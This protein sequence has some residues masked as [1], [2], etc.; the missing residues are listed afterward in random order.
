MRVLSRFPFIL[1]LCMTLCAST[2]LAQSESDKFD[3]TGALS[4]SWDADPAM[5]RLN[6]SLHLSATDGSW[7][8]AVYNS[9]FA[10]NRVSMQWAAAPAAD[11]DGAVASGLLLVDGTSRNSNGYFVYY[12]SSGNYYLYRLEGGQLQTPWLD[13]SPSSPAPAP[14]G[15]LQIDYW[16]GNIN[17]YLD[18]NLKATLTDPQGERYT[19]QY[20]GI[21]LYPNR[22]NDIDGFK[23]EYSTDI[24]GGG[25]GEP[26]GGGGGTVVGNLI[27][28]TD[29]FCQTD[30]EKWAYDPNAMVANCELGIDAASDDGWDHVSVNKRAGAAGAKIVYSPDNSQQINGYIPAGFAILMDAASPDANGYLITKR[31][32]VVLYQ[33]SGGVVGDAIKN[34]AASQ[35][36]PTPGG[37]IKVII[38]QTSETSKFIQ[39]YVDDQL[40]VEFTFDNATPLENA[41]VGAV[42]YSTSSST[43]LANIT[44][45]TT[46]IEGGGDPEN[47][48]MV[49]GDGQSGLIEQWLPDTLKVKVTAEDGETPVSDVAVDFNIIQPLNTGGAEL[50]VNN[51]QF[52]GRLWAEAEI[53]TMSPGLGQVVADN[54]A[55]NQQAVY[56]NYVAG[57]RG[58]VA[59][60]VPFYVPEQRT[61][62]VYARYK[63]PSLDENRYY[64]EIDGANR[65]VR[66][67][68]V[69]PMTAWNWNLV[70]PSITLDK[71]NHTV[72]FVVYHTGWSIDKILIVDRQLGYTPG[73]EGG[74]GPIFPNLTDNR[75]IAG[76]LVKFGTKADSNVVVR[77]SVSKSDGTLLTPVD[78]VLNPN[79]GPA[80]TMIQN[81]NTSYPV[82]G[83][84]GQ[85]TPVSVVVMDQYDNR[86][87]GSNITWQLVK[88]Q[89]ATVNPSVSQSDQSGIASTNVTLG[90]L[91]TEYEVQAV[92]AALSGSPHTIPI[93][94]GETP[95]RVEPVSGANQTAN[96]GETLPLP[97]VVKVSKD[98]GSGFANYPV[99][100]NVTLGDGTVKN[101][102]GAEEGDVITINTDA[103][104]L[105]QVYWTLDP[106]VGNDNQVTVEAP[107]VAGSG[108]TFT[109]TGTLGPPEKF[110][111]VSGDN[112][113]G[114]ILMELQDPFVVRV[115]DKHDNPIA[116]HKVTFN[117][118]AGSNAKLINPLDPIAAPDTFL[119][120]YTDVNGEAKAKLIMGNQI[121]ELHQVT[122]TAQNLTPVH[123]FQASPSGR[124]ASQL[125]MVSGDDQ[126]APVTQDLLEDFV[127]Q[128]L[129]PDDTPIEGHPVRFEVIKGGGNISGQAAR[130]VNTDENGYA[131]IRLSL[132][133]TAGDTT[134]AV[135]VTSYREGSTDYHLDNSPMKFYASASPG[136]A[137]I[138]TTDGPDTLRAPAGSTV[139]VRARVTDIYNNPVSGHQV[140]FE[141]QGGGGDLID[142]QGESSSKVVDTNDA[143]I[144]VVSWRMP[145]EVGFYQVLAIAI[146]EGGQFLSGAPLPFPGIREPGLAQNLTKLNADTLVGTVN[147]ELDE[148][149]RVKVTDQYG[150]PVPNFR[151]VFRVTEGGGK[152]NG[153]T[154][155]EA[156]TSADSGIAETSWVLG[157][158]AGVANNLVEARAAISQGGLIVFKATGQPDTPKRM[159]VDQAST[160]QAG[161]V[162][163]KLSYPI[164][165][166]VVDQFDNGVP[167]HQVVFFVSGE[168]SIK[169]NIDGMPEQ[170]VMT[171]NNGWAEVEWTLGKRPGSLNNTMIVSSKYNQ[172]DLINSPYTFRASSSVGN[173]YKVVNITANKD[174]LKTATNSQLPELLKVK[175][176]DQFDNPI[177]NHSVTY[178]VLS[179]VDAGGGGIDDTLTTEKTVKTNSEGVAAVKFYTGKF[180]GNKRNHVVARAE[181]NGTQ[182]L[183]S[184]VDFYIS[185]YSTNADHI[186]IYDGNNQVAAVGEDLPKELMVIARD[187]FDNPVRQ[188]QPV[189]FRVIAGDGFFLPDSLREKTVT[190]GTNGI[191]KIRW[192]LGTIAGI[193]NNVVEV[194]ANNGVK[195]LGTLR[196]TARANA[197]ITSAVKSTII[198][199][200]AT[201]IQVSQ[202]SNKATI[203][204]TLRDKFGNP[205]VNKAV[206]LEA[207]GQ[208]P[209]ISQPTQVSD[210]NGQVTGAIASMTAGVKYVWARDMNN[211]ITVADSVEV[212]FVPLEAYRIEKASGQNGDQQT[213]NT[214]TVLPHPLRVVVV[215]MFDNPIPDYQVEYAV[216]SGGGIF[217]DGV[218]V[219][220][221]SS[222]VGSNRFQLGNEQFNSVEVRAPGLVGSPQ[223]FIERGINSPPSNIMIVDGNSQQAGPGNELPNPLK[224]RVVDQSQ[225]PL[226][227]VKVRFD[228]V[229]NKGTI[230]GQNVQV[231]D[232]NGEAK[233]RV[234][235]GTTIGANLYGVSLPDYQAL[236]PVTFS[237]KTTVILGQ[238][239]RLQLSHGNQQHT[240]VGQQFPQPFIV[241][242][243]DDF[244]NPVP[245][246]PV[247]F[248][249]LDDGSYPGIGTFVDGSKSYLAKTD[250]QGQARVYYQAGTVAGINKVTACLPSVQG[251]IDFEVVGDPDY[252]FSMHYH[253]GNGTD[254]LGQHGEKG[255]PLLNPVS[256]IIRDQYGNPAPNG[257]VHFSVLSPTHGRIQ[258]AQ[259]VLSNS[260]GIAQATWIIGDSQKNQAVALSYLPGN[261]EPYQVNFTAWGDD[262][263][264]PKLQNM[265]GDMTVNEG[266][267]VSFTVQAR[268]DDGDQL[269]YTVENLPDSAE[270]NPVTHGFYW[271]PLYSQGSP[272]GKVYSPVFVV[273]D[274][275]GGKDMY[276]LNIKVYNVSIPPTITFTSPSQ[277]LSMTK[278]VT[279][280]FV[281]DAYDPDGQQVFYTWYVD[282]VAV[283]TGS[284]AF[285]FYPGS[286]VYGSHSV[287]V[288]VSDMDNARTSHQ[289]YLQLKTSVELNTFSCSAAPYQGV[290]L[291]WETASEVDNSGF[292]VYRSLSKEGTYKKINTELILSNPE[293]RYEFIDE[294]VQ[295]GREYFYK[296]EDVSLYGFQT[297]H[298]PVSIQA[299]VPRDFE[300][301]QNFPNPFN[302]TTMIRFQLPK[303]VRVRL[304]IYNIQGQLVNTLVD[305][306]RETGY[307]ELVWNGR[308]DAG[309]LVSSGVY[310]Y[311]LVA[312]DFTMTRKMAF[313]K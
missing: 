290:E 303:P 67:D 266:Q 60:E 2:L 202:G 184:P 168:D 231:T 239:E 256:V 275:R 80:T 92:N 241:I 39:F 276:R 286:Y 307:H 227:G 134:Q 189:T 259:P 137:S 152:V 263:K 253:S 309:E 181:F 294:Q 117:K 238:A 94:I 245:D 247:T 46:Y 250:Q 222:G 34:V 113:Q 82:P 95:D 156:I 120:A 38:Q 166:R 128:I 28:T 216:V 136:P 56:V 292:N 144:A 284:N 170:Q 207:S 174:S 262:N 31:N 49:S 180:A 277:Q 89:G 301:S 96:A 11:A 208:N 153:A 205:V 143:G 235:V 86:V 225:W 103:N 7:R 206:F 52:D 300:L 22:N 138:L 57:S 169:G 258:E 127:V 269:Y 125:V 232:Q 237:A 297:K 123:S 126:I 246:V 313:L 188:A 83:Y 99:K 186:E 210:V 23:V 310:Y 101:V 295:A 17:V 69:A 199:S 264:Y 162:G 141:V 44:E 203:V 42:Q 147:Q 252:P 171:G 230:L 242:A 105:A 146:R 278:D 4:A 13:Y 293:R 78:F 3:G 265:P 129:A 244:D 200:P 243:K 139:E 191:A 257:S 116:G 59:F 160:G 198:A 296:I 254:G 50:S 312:D 274:S 157:R 102:N 285:T 58:Q 201:P 221:D 187:Q 131:R 158:N 84:A 133:T 213:R 224:V 311:R 41:Y 43:N 261:N 288:I 88:G 65:T 229:I 268:D 271:K 33:I 148:K 204:V 74:S 106:R 145:Q 20:G 255:Q 193:N 26:G 109:A 24:G 260:K 35:P 108:F 304:D 291:F 104:G 81:P 75:G 178:Q 272:E 234:T 97:L 91:D 236:T 190:T 48:E 164:R 228:V 25:G 110:T 248:S 85:S 36:N 179:R 70:Y 118:T 267:P 132:G 154:Q 175:V 87:G 135:R 142:T 114:P 140:T 40:D 220:T 196:F 233:V 209:I 6:G 167:N 1:I 281:V 18:G 302:P 163:E 176:T 151:V 73:G 51:F 306:I 27:G 282:G 211:S 29:D 283:Y 223:T 217:L 173:P 279:Q 64:V 90:F 16:D 55:S 77:A 53:G 100:F 194:T 289:W 270:F 287:K 197:D 172:N 218:T 61:F 68:F 9:S 63:A 107:A 124:S 182:L 165:V 115:T 155:T 37:S 45:Y 14:A 185:A 273:T 79:P 150:N 299:A 98:D 226:A 112:Q 111:K 214:G 12:H 215:D 212:T 62:E 72:G 54:Q 159:N 219:R 71:G 66:R 177:A 121:G 122:A 251:C 10:A 308:N 19:V 119:V 183:Y 30:T 8:F 130:T 161:N 192:R 47:V 32:S 240:T 195:N 280:N 149:I 15:H 305:A 249:V 5:A 298:G 76:T 93:L 21:G